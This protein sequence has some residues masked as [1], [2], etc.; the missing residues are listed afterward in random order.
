MQS[1]ARYFFLADILFLVAYPLADVLLCR[2]VLDESPLAFRKT[3]C[4]SDTLD[5]IQYRNVY[6][7]A[8]VNLLAPEFGI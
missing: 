6:G 2:I 3:W 7:T 1:I 4:T 8:A 5:N